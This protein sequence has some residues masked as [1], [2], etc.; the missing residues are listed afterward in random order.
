MPWQII[1]F[2]ER[3][4]SLHPNHRACF[5]AVQHLARSSHLPLATAFY[6]LDTIGA[7]VK[8]LSLPLALARQAIRADPRHRLRFL[9]SLGGYLQAIR[10]MAAHR[11]QLV[12]FRYLYILTSVYMYNNELVKL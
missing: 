8:F 9:S 2:D 4:V 11:S 7:P 12:W 5:A 6:A 1:T 10:A 3:G